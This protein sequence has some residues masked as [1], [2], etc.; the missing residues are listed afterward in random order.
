MQGVSLEQEHL[1]SLSKS[2]GANG[3][4]IGRVVGISLSEPSSCVHPNAVGS[5]LG[6][7]GS[8]AFF[9]TRATF[10]WNASFVGGKEASFGAPAT[11]RPTLL[12]HIFWRASVND[13]HSVWS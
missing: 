5:I 3:M 10:S 12:A 2:S 8:R 1:T 13:L 9:Q 7:S 6:G 11:L 4:S